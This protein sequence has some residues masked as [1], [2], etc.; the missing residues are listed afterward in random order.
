MSA[1]FRF[2]REQAIDLAA[3]PE[4]VF[5][6]LKDHDRLVA[7]MGKPWLMMVRGVMRVETDSPTQRARAGA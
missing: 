2:Y 3:S 1:Q 5:N 4:L 6:V 7:H